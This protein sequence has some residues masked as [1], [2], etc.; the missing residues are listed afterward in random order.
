MRA[1]A[2]SNGV[3]STESELLAT[4]LRASPMAIYAVDASGVVVVWSESAERLFGWSRAEAVG[5]RDP[6]LAPGSSPEA[7]VVAEP[8]TR[9]EIRYTRSGAPLEVSLSLSQIP[10]AGGGRPGTL[11]MATDTSLTRRLERERL[12]LLERERAALA[13]AEAAD[14]RARFLSTGSALLDGSLDYVVTLN[15]LARLAVPG[16]ADYCLVD[17][18]E[19][20]F[21]SRV[22]V[23][24]RDPVRQEWLYRKARQPLA[25]D[26]ERHPVVRVMLTGEPLRVEQA[27]EEV[28]VSLA[29]DQHHLER[30]RA[31]ELNSFMVVPLAARGR[32]L[33]VIT[34]A[35]AESGRRYT[36]EDLEMAAELGRRAGLAVEA[37][38]LYQAS[39]RAVQARERLLAIVSHDL[40][41]SLATILLN[42]SAVL[43]APSGAGVAPPVFEQLQWIARSAEQMS[44]LISDL[45]DASAIELGRFSIE[46][47]VRTVAELVGYAVA[48]YRPLAA[49]KGIGFTWDEGE[50]LP[51][52]LVDAERV[53]QVLGNL[54][55]NAIKFCS[56][57]DAIMLTASLHSEEEVL[58]SVQDTG[59]GI[60]P[61]DLPTI[62]DFYQQ[63]S[64][65]R[66]RGAGLGLAIARAIVE[67]HRGRIFA[68]ATPGAGSTFS[69][70]LPTSGAESAVHE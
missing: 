11:V 45:L 21:V 50:N 59:P 13:D 30:L 51:P 56:R 42:A 22:A 36:P 54:L 8:T 34:F 68:E 14:Y 38:R 70:T 55:G 39:C 41:N 17:E 49:E 64:K 26:P 47:S 35:Y 32:I 24:H 43:E 61:D 15:N 29:H 65:G 63:G 5:G 3:M 2:P 33:G 31:I 40:R 53:H 10:D 69:F 1:V 12:Q 57:G 18:L 4:L 48:L 46:P 28:L 37:A 25:G 67:A 6:T 9:D 60:E 44:R 19:D 16:L 7:A 23:A 62:F 27:T 20:E 58:L 52:V 66:G